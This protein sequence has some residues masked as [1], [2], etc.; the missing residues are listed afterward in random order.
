MSYGRT[1]QWQDDLT[2]VR[3]SSDHQ[4]GACVRRE[5][6]YAFRI[7]RQHDTRHIGRKRCASSIRVD[8]TIR[9]VIDTTDAERRGSAMNHRAFVHKHVC[10]QCPKP[11]GDLGGIVVVVVI[12]ENCNNAIAR[13]QRA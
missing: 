4:I 1:E 5:L 2:A 11:C 3:M 13:T 6:Q 7:V 8:V 12:P 9:P 10:A